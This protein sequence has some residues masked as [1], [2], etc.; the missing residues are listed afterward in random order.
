MEL[1]SKGSLLSS[2]TRRGNQLSHPSET[3]GITYNG[4][5][6]KDDLVDFIKDNAS[7][8]EDVKKALSGATTADL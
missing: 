4:D 8:A 1:T 2:T 3:S 5:R 6:E 7:N